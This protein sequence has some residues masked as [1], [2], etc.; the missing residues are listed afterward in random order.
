[1]ARLSASARRSA[2]IALPVLSEVNLVFRG[3]CCKERG[4]EPKTVHNHWKMFRAIMNWHSKQKDEPARAWYPTLPMIPDHEQRWFTQDEMGKIANAAK[5]QFKVLFHLAGVSGLR[6]GELCGLHVDDLNFDRG[7]I[8]VRRSVWHGQEVSTKTKRGYRD[9]RI[10]TI[11]VRMLREYLG[12]RTTGRVFQT[13][14]GTPLENHNLVR[15]VLKPICV[16]LGIEPGGMHAFRH[17][18]VSHLQAS[19]VPGDF[20]KR[21]VGHSSLRTTSYYTHFS[22]DFERETVERVGPSWTH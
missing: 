7:V 2:E 6:S 1:M 4:L 11:T 15:Q 16:R 14:A 21:Q 9:V 8:Q 17:G 10:D 12:G 3:C 20:I 13:R 22:D 18:R 19:N 5:G